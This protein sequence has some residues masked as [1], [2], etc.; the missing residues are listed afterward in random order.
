MC[1]Q[2]FCQHIYGIKYLKWSAWGKFSVIISTIYAARS[3]YIVLMNMYF[4]RHRRLNVG[5]VYIYIAGVRNVQGGVYRIREGG[6]ASPHAHNDLQ[7]LM[8]HTRHVY[9]LRVRSTVFDITTPLGQFSSS[10]KG[11]LKRVFMSCFLEIKWF[12][13]SC[14]T[15]ILMLLM[16]ACIVINSSIVWFCQLWLFF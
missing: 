5:L 16:I 11:L 10:L 1:I 14:W 4:G 8:F 15:I 13:C 3:T 9:S 6:M 7:L 2:Y 12:V